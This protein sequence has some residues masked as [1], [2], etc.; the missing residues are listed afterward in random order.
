[1]TPLA[2]YSLCIFHPSHCQRK[3]IQGSACIAAEG[4]LGNGR[5]LDLSV[6]GCLVETGLHLKAGQPLRL[7]ITY[8]AGKPLSIS[9]AVV[10]WLNG[11]RAGIE[12]IR[13]SEEDQV[14]LR[15]YVG[16]QE[17]CRQPSTARWSEAV[18][19]TGISGV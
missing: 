19:C 9:L 1:V 14:R 4:L 15:W 3:G 16:F 5:V 10:R 13:M 2:A 18:M 8:G 7:R 17:H 11:R 6:P 12:F